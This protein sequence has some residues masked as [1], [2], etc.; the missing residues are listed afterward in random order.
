ML[1]IS[2]AV[3]P[4]APA[5]AVVEEGS[6]GS[7]SSLLLTSDSG[8]NWKVLSNPCEG[9]IPAGLVAITS[10]HWGLYCVLDGGM[11]QGRTRLYTTSDKG[12]TWV[13]IAEGN[14]E[15]P[16]RGNIGAEMAFDLTLSGNGRVLWLLGVAGGAQQTDGAATGHVP[17]S[18]GQLRH[19]ACRRRTHQCLAPLPGYGLYRTTNGTTWTELA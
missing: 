6:E 17:D 14:V 15:G 3:R 1:E 12:K 19:Q 5:S 8:E 13:L 9:L 2:H 10:A 16:N 11:E 7:P 4:S 18:E